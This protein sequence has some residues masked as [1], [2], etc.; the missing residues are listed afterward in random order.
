MRVPCVHRLLGPVKSFDA[1]PVATID[2]TFCKIR[3][4]PMSWLHSSILTVALCAASLSSAWAEKADR[5]K[6]LNAEADEMR[7]D[8]I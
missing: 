1:H 8:D 2:R 6:P 4:S 3:A 7:Q 5:F